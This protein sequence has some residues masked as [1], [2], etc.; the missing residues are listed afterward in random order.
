MKT[1]KEFVNEASVGKADVEGAS[2]RIIKYLE[3]RIGASYKLVDGQNYSNSSGSYFGVLYVSDDNKAIRVNWDDGKFHSINVWN[4]YAT[5]MAPAFEIF[6]NKIAPGDSSFVKLLPEIAEII[7]N[8]GYS[9]DDDDLGDEEELAEST[10]NEDFEYNGEVYKDK[11]SIVRAM[12]DAGENM[13]TIKQVTRL[14]PGYIRSTIEK[15]TGSA[16]PK[17]TKGGLKVVK[18]A[19]ET[20]TPSKATKKAQAILDDTEYADPEI[21]FSDLSDYCTLIGK[22]LMPALMI[23]GQGGIGKSFTVTDVLNKYG[24]K[25][26]DYVIMK[27]RCTPSAMYKFLYY[28]YNQICVF[29]D[30]DSI[31]NSEDGM[32]ILKGALD[33]GNPREIS[34]MTKGADIVD[35]FGI[36][37]HDEIESIMAQWSAD[38]NGREGTPS[39]F[40]FNGAV[41]FIS[42]LTKKDIYKKDRAILSRCTVIDIVLRAKDVINRIQ[43]VLPHIKVF[44]I[45]GRNIANDEGKKIVFEWISSEEFLNDPRMRG[46]EVN[47]RL[48]NQVY[49]FWYAGL[50]NWKNLAYRAGG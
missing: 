25:G 32:N 14:S 1:F 6:T 42:N 27:G 10:I 8:G 18:G 4:D 31:F 7:V 20:L 28:H 9:D 41:I 45:R 39:Y 38:H 50:E 35:T 21:V 49:A 29:D 48:F 5:E 24:K 33:S 43:T 34:W 12:Y 19:A 26:E 16:A 37:D 47:F 13:D 40:Q 22:G 15:Y 30:C 11:V 3:K 46:K 23:T 36:E 17:T 44:D 2:T